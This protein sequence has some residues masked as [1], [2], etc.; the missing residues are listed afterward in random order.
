MRTG[1]PA[2]TLCFSPL[3]PETGTWPT[4]PVYYSGWMEPFQA[5]FA[6]EVI[7]CGAVPLVQ[8]DPEGISLAAIARSQRHGYLGSFAEALHNFGH[9]VI[10]SFGHEMNGRLIL[11]G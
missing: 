9:P 11:V 4:W 1:M 2:T 3:A 6:E 8:I 10:I 7:A 5:H